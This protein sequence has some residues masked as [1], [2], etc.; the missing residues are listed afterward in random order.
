MIS[1]ITNLSNNVASQLDPDKILVSLLINGQSI[2]LYNTNQ[3]FVAS[4]SYNQKL[5]DYLKG[6]DNVSVQR[7][8]GFLARKDL[9]EYYI[10]IEYDE[11]K[12]LKDVLSDVEQL[13]ELA[14]KK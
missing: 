6:N 9:D 12:K 8:N 13:Y 7:G 5:A 10:V 4:F 3:R 11:D 1:I 14:T 2:S